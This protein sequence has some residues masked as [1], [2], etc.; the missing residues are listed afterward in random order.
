MAGSRVG[1]VKTALVAG[2]DA[3]STFDGVEVSYAFRFGSVERERVWCGRARATHDPASLKS[4]RNFRNEQMTIDV[5]VHVEGVDLTAEETETRALVLGTALEEYV[6]DN[7]QG[8]GVTGM[9]SLTITG[10]ESNILANDRGHLC[11]LAYELSYD[12]RLT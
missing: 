11:Q 1:A 4:G 5:I 12:A 8:L 3:L 2:L 7:K 9:N 10:V 6:A